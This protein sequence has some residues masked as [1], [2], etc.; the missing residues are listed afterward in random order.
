[1]IGVH[2]FSTS[3][4]SFL[5]VKKGSTGTLVFT[6]ILIAVYWYSV[7]CDT[8]SLYF[9]AAMLVNQENRILNTFFYQ[10]CKK[11]AGTRVLPVRKVYH[12]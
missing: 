12:L 6:G 4:S 10:S 1:M 11:A 7:F 9:T 5:F 2:D 8:D 3:S